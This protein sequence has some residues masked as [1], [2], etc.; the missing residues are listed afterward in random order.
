MM[1]N[2]GLAVHSDDLAGA[3]RSYLVAV[4]S[5][6]PSAYHRL[7]E[8]AGMLLE[9]CGN[10]H[11]RGA[12]CQRFS[13]RV[14]GRAIASAAEF[15][16]AQQKF[17]RWDGFYALNEVDQDGSLLFSCSH[18]EES[19]ACRI[20]SSRPSVCREYPTQL[21]GPFAP[22]I[23]GCGYELKLRSPLGVKQLKWQTVRQISRGLIEA[24]H[25]SAAWQLIAEGGHE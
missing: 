13:L 7:E 19:G 15:L 20:Y 14:G 8:L 16:E 18:L 24:G 25:V 10:C 11:R 17:E 12:C 3:E 21:R 4:E 22:L 9:W 2:N 6:D 1:L 23:L 5:G